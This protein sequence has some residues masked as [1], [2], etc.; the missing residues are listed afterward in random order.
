MNTLATAVIDGRAEEQHRDPPGART[1][2][3]RSPHRPG[4]STCGCRGDAGTGRRP[5]PR[6]TASSSS[7]R[8]APT[9]TATERHN[10]S[11]VTAVLNALRGGL[12]ADQLIEKVPGLPPHRL[13][14]AYRDLDQRRSV[15]ADAWR[16][17]RRRRHAVGPARARQRC[18][19][20]SCRC[21]SSACW[22]RPTSA[23]RPYRTTITRLASY[24][25]ATHRNVTEIE[26]AL[27]L[28]PERAVELGARLYNPY[29]DAITNRVDHLA[30]RVGTLTPNRVAA[31][32]GEAPTGGCPPGH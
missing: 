14:A 4:R 19:P 5:R 30:R 11:D 9:P 12:T 15:A 6:N 2:A 7:W 1:A 13:L 16:S 3:C 31:L 29:G 18:V 27:G 10:R 28:W 8:C 20:R 22:R 26:T 21:S 17:A 23:P 25:D 24:V 32:L